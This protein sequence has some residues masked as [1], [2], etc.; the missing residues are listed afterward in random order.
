[1]IRWNKIGHNIQKYIWMKE[2]EAF[3]PKNATL[4][5]SMVVVVICS[6]AALLSANV[7]LLV[8][9]NTIPALNVAEDTEEPADYFFGWNV[10]P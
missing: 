6:E 9:H 1:M 10:S 7:L 2:G 8:K 3:N 5:S 4:M